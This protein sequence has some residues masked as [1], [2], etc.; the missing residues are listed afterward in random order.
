LS[1]GWAALRVHLLALLGRNGATGDSAGSAAS[2][3]SSSSR[4]EVASA[5]IDLSEQIMQQVQEEVAAAWHVMEAA[6]NARAGRLVGSLNAQLA[7]LS[8]RLEG[9][10]EDG[11]QACFLA[12]PG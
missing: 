2:S 9:A 12:V 3:G 4:D 5:L 7:T 6:T 10:V 11:L 8:A 1:R